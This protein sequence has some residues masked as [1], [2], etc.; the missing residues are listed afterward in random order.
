[1]SQREVA[2]K[3]GVRRESVQ[4]WELG[5]FQ[6]RVSCLPNVIE[7]LGYDPRPEPTTWPE[8]LVWYRE[9]RGLSQEVMAEQL[10]VAPR[11][12]GLWETGRRKPT[13]EN[14]AKLSALRG[15]CD[16]AIYPS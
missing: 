13:I 3:T 1:L 8:W 11:T 2:R 4:Q 12:L 10:G 14:L 6:P 9:S 15:D 5:Y 7:F 16:D